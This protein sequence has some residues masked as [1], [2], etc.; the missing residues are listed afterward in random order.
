MKVVSVYTLIG[1]LICCGHIAEPSLDIKL[2]WSAVTKVRFWPF[3]IVLHILFNSWQP[4]KSERTSKTSTWAGMCRPSKSALLYNQIEQVGCWERTEDLFFLFTGDSNGKGTQ[5]PVS[6]LHPGLFWIPVKTVTGPEQNGATLLSEA[7]NVLITECLSAVLTRWQECRYFP[8]LF[9][10]VL[11]VC[12]LLPLLSPMP[13]S[14]HLHHLFFFAAP[15][16]EPNEIN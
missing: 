8:C 16:L 5:T 12:L 3:F 13:P 7:V 2:K 10:F 15:T 6:V 4:Y 14:T 11:A 9:F 1:F